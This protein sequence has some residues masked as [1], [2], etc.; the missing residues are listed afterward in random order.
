M[1][2]YVLLI[3]IS[4]L[5][6]LDISNT[7]SNFLTQN[8][9][10]QA[11]KIKQKTREPSTNGSSKKNVPYSSKENII[12]RMIQCIKTCFIERKRCPYP[13]IRRTKVG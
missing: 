2:S 6:N 1:H 13:K 4:S 12:E 9:T 8:F 11:Y 10:T 5:L 7:I 3:F